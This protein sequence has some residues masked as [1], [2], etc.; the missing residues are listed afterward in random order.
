MLEAVRAG[1]HPPAWGLCFS[2]S[3]SWMELSPCA[4][5]AQQSLFPFEVLRE[6]Q[7]VKKPRSRCKNLFQWIII[8]VSG[9][10]S[11]GMQS[12]A[13]CGAHWACLWAEQ[14]RAG[15]LLELLMDLL[16]AAGPGDGCW[17]WDLSQT[18]NFVSV[19]LLCCDKKC[20]TVQVSRGPCE[21]L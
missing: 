11:R 2:I 4:A 15:L 9:N 10:T 1:S 18:L 19:Q 17:S 3:A 8:G 16:Q 21:A 20:C 12:R 5:R 7:E 6:L 13:H 14:L